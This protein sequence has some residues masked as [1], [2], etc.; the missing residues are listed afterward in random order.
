MEERFTLDFDEWFDRGTPACPKAVVCARLIA[1]PHAR[2]FWPSE[3][4]DGSVR[5]DC[6]RVLVRGVKLA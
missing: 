2:G 5:I 1:G 4:E 3:R 6:V